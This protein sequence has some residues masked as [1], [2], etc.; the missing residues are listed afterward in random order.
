MREALASIEAQSYRPIE[1]IIVDDG[2]EDETAEVIAAFRPT[3]LAVHSIRLG[4]VGVSAARNAALDEAN[5]DYVSF[6][7]ADDLLEPSALRRLVGRLH[8]ADAD[9]A[10]GRSVNFERPNAVWQAPVPPMALTF[11]EPSAGN[12]IL[13]RPVPSAFV[14]RRSGVRFRPDLDVSEWLDFFLSFVAT[15]PRVAFLDA[16]VTGMR[17]H[18]TPHRAS[19]A[20]DHFEPSHRL[21]IVKNWLV[22]FRRCPGVSADARVALEILA[23]RLALDQFRRYGDADPVLFE[24]DLASI[25]ARD[26]AP[27]SW[28]LLRRIRLTT[29]LPLL[30]AH[31]RTKSAAQGIGHAC[32]SFFGGAA[33]TGEK[34]G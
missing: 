15:G 9:M 26:L 22:A 25:C 18:G 2:S 4:G 1:V 28:R 30:L 21:E 5:G 6:L 24:V 12:L 17:Q 20:H 34:K 8:A 3:D 19:N 33:L 10:V 11:A 32:R 7:D 14:M 13:H 16:L 29:G 23:F 31:E 27:R